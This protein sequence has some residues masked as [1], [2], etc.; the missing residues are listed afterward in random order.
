MKLATKIIDRIHLKCSALW[1]SSSGHIH[2]NVNHSSGLLDP[3][4]ENHRN[5][6]EGFWTTKIGLECHMT[7]TTSVKENISS[8]E[9]DDIREQMRQCPQLSTSLYAILHYAV[10][11]GLYDKR[12]IEHC[13]C[14]IRNLCYGLQQPQQQQQ[15]QQNHIADQQ[16]QKQQKS[17]KQLQQPQSQQISRRS[18]TPS[19]QESKAQLT[20]EKSHSNSLF[21]IKSSSLS[22]GK[23]SKRSMD[24][25]G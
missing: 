1:I 24:F 10:D 6:I 8:S 20:Q 18:V 4:S 9:D 17:Q 12:S 5:S 14:T 19:G 21:R 15:Q 13:V 22:S 3:K 7:I 23:K 2:R 25:E 11:H 16:H